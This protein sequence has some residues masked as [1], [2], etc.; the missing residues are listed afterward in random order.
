MKN[1]DNQKRIPRRW[2]AVILVAVM[3]A[4]AATCWL[5]FERVF[6]SYVP[7]T[8]ASDRAG[9][10]MEPG[11]RI[12]LRGVDV[13]RVRKIVSTGNS[14]VR[15][16]LE[17]LKS[18]LHYIPANVGA[19]ITANTAFGSK[20]IDL[21]LPQKPS[22]ARLSAGTVLHAQ[23][24]STEVN[25]VFDN[26][27]TLIQRIDP[28]KLN[29]V[30]SALAEGLRGRGQQLGEA[31]AGANSVL[32]AL[33]A[34]S[35]VI[36]ANWRELAAFSDTYGEAAQNILSILDSAATTGASIT[37]RARAMDALL[38]NAIGLANSGTAMLA[39]N[40]ENVVDLVNLLRPTTGLLMKYQPTFTC[41]LVGAKW[42]LDNGGYAGAGGNGRTLLVDAAVLLGNDPY[43]HPNNLPIVA[44]KGG[45][46]GRP[47]CGSLPHAHKNFP[48]RALVTN[49]GWSTGIDIRPNPGLGHPCYANYLP[50]T[51]A[52]PEPASVR[53]QGPPSP[54]LPVAPPPP[55]PP[56]PP[57]P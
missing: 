28:V 19:E 43:V 49:T 13:G 24:V 4:Y 15:L 34:R 22:A 25:T 7:V 55:P 36:N 33:N 31:F 47:S 53:C 46:D 5:A 1:R 32:A 3:V 2:W 21:T 51:R 45:P 29:G 50:V 8:L 30:L 56:P 42:W 40:A 10:M 11:G 20:Y 12:K 57:H 6:T 23:N 52:A 18:Q 41:L 9:L 39:P 48:V 54:G 14:P 44:A 35:E 38:L 26:L 27:V 37:D 17:I 16:E